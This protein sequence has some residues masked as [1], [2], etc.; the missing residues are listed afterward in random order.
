LG[1]YNESLSQEWLLKHIN[2]SL[3]VLYAHPGSS[4]ASTGLKNGNCKLELLWEGKMH[5]EYACRAA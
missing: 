1:N 2:N 4:R 5:M 3:K